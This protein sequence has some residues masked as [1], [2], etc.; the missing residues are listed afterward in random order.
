[1]NE[2]TG[3]AII[4]ARFPG[5]MTANARKCVGGGSRPRGGRRALFDT[6]TPFS[7]VFYLR[8]LLRVR[9]TKNTLIPSRPAR[10]VSRDA[11]KPTSLAPLSGGESDAPER[12]RIDAAA[13]LCYSESPAVLREAPGEAHERIVPE[14]SCPSTNTLYDRREHEE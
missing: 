10:A 5:A 11:G 12:A 3:S 6:N 4:P 8:R 14:R 2:A 9:K 13:L 7:V 1:M